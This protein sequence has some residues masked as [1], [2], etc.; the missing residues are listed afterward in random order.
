[1]NGAHQL[2]KEMADLLQQDMQE[3]ERNDLEADTDTNS[4]EYRRFES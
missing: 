2:I 4:S 3:G 1:M